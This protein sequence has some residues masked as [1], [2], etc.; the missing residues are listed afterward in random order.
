MRTASCISDNQNCR[1]KKRSEDVH[2]VQ[3]VADEV[4][5]FEEGVVVVPAYVGEV[6]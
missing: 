6:E 1:Y 5:I 3:R 2:E 4:K